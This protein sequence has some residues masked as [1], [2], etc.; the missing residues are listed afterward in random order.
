MPSVTLRPATAAEGAGDI[1][2]GAAP[3]TS[4][5]FVCPASTISPRQYPL[6]VL[7]ATVNQ[8][9]WPHLSLESGCTRAGPHSRIIHLLSPSRVTA[10]PSPVLLPNREQGVDRNT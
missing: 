5:R 9:V 10:P 4:T 3:L 2:L 1:L 7:N 8:A 6:A